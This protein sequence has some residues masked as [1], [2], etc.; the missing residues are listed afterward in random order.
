MTTERIAALDALLIETE[1]AHGAYE[2]TELSGVY[3][4]E[5]PRW[6]AA[7]A[8]EHGLGKIIGRPVGADEPTE[9]LTRSW[10]ELQRADPKPSEPW[11]TTVARGMAE[12]L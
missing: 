10:S 11:T 6:Y 12:E 3:D 8:I 1:Q 4:Q 5:W 9:F 7:Y 2:T